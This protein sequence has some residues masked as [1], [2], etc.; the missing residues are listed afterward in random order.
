MPLTLALG[1]AC[2]AVA[3]YGAG[4]WL[5]RHPLPWGTLLVNTIGC[6]LFG[7]I[8]AHAMSEGASQTTLFLAAFCG[9]FT[10][11][12][13]FALQSLILRRKNGTGRAAFYISLHLIL[14]LPALY[15]G[16]SLA[17]SYLS[18]GGTTTSHV[19][20]ANENA[21]TSSNPLPS[22]ASA[23][24]ATCGHIASPSLSPHAR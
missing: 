23:I 9:T 12:S 20:P 13:S 4:L 17:A 18:P 24:S 11:V 5:D 2:G 21:Q 19:A 1:A 15:A 8:A 22:E 7:F 3:R 6:F 10:T 16:H 14:C